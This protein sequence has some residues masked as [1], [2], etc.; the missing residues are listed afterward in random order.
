MLLK[1]LLAA[2]LAAVHYRC[3]T[4]LLP[5][6]L[7]AAGL[8]ALLAPVVRVRS[9]PALAKTMH[10]VKQYVCCLLC[11]CT[12]TWLSTRLP[13]ILLLLLLLLLKSCVQCCACCCQCLKQV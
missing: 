12:A 2:A 13:E 7:L 11:I 10:K 8:A 5:A 1:D 6:L 9:A 4:L 3:E